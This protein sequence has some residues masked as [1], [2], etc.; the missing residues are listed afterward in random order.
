MTKTVLELDLAGYSDIARQLEEQLGVRTVSQFN[1]QIQG[2]VDV[3]LDAVSAERSQVVMAT[4]GDGAILVFDRAENAH[5]FAQ[6]VHDAT[7]THNEKVSIASSKRWFR[8]GA[9]TGDI[10]V[11]EVD[12]HREIAGVTIANAVRL[13]SAARV[14]EIV[15]DTTTFESLPTA[16]RR[17]YGEEEEVKGKRKET[18]RARRCVMAPS[19]AGTATEPTVVGVLNLFDQLHP[20]DQLQ[21]VMILISMP[22]EHRPAE[23]LSVS[24][25][26]EQ[27]LDWAAGHPSGLKNLD[28]TLRSLIEKQHRP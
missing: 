8:M 3:G 19:E 17:S 22:V 15:I 13:E 6:A 27:I 5:R 28:V 26:Q 25:R 18:F 7:R 21:R 12:G 2:F 9:A 4:T 24:R 1:V 10:D 23:T 16:L 14:G 11:R 20:R